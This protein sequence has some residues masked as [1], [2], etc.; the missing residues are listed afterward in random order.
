MPSAP[1]LAAPPP[2]ARAA[3]PAAPAAGFQRA[4]IGSGSG[5][6]KWRL[7]ILFYIRYSRILDS[8]MSK[9]HSS[10]MGEVEKDLG[11]SYDNQKD[12]ERNTKEARPW[13]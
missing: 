6:T 9:C 8:A 11:Y 1:P 5:A 3:A 2:A 4:S 7:K 10:L 12:E 13:V